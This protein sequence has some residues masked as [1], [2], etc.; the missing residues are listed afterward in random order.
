MNTET[1]KSYRNELEMRD[2]VINDAIR[3]IQ[4]IR[5]MSLLPYEI[6]QKV[7]EKLKKDVKQKFSYF[8]AKQVS[9]MLYV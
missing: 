1:L 8:K 5:G 2:M 3:E 7:Q 9:L 6:V 4:K